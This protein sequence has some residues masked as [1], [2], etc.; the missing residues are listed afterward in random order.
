MANLRTEHEEINRTS[1][2]S[3]N[4]RSITF[5]KQ[6]GSAPASINNFPL[7]DDQPFSINNMPGEKEVTIFNITFG[8]GSKSVHVFRQFEV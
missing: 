8:S 5:I 3:S 6:S 1:E 4:C 2:I 7:V